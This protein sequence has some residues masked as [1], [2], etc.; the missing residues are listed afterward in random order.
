MSNDESPN[1][2]PTEQ[3]E[4][5]PGQDEPS[6]VAPNEGLPPGSWV[7]LVG[8]SA[9][10]GDAVG[11]LIRARGHDVVTI[12]SAI[13]AVEF[14]DAA[15]F[16]L[17]VISTAL[18]TARGVEL[19][20]RLRA[21]EA[22]RSRRVPI[23]AITEPGRPLARAAYLSAGADESL[24]A[25]LR[26]EVLDD[27]LARHVRAPDEHFVPKL[28]L[29]AA[30]GEPERLRTTLRRFETEAPAR[31]AS[32]RGA[33]QDADAAS[34]GVSAEALEDFAHRVAMRRVRDLCHRIAAHA[35]RGEVEEAG[36]L[37]QELHEAVDRGTAAA[38]RSIE[39]A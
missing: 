35:R 26:G 10:R 22:L 33:L 39:V 5:T 7:L 36:R 34:L 18:E 31:L 19:V 32:M 27:A 20:R 2:W 25:P 21:L 12:D 13:E 37:I 16:A 15:E 24:D 8:P 11:S 4:S 23:F 28:A 3:A 9:S 17:V 1:D 30:A 14:V 29:E 6:R 38:R